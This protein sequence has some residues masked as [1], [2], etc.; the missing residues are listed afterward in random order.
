MLKLL[1]PGLAVAMAL[2]LQGCASMSPETCAASDWHQV[3]V[4][5]GEKGRTSDRIA[6]YQ[7]DCGKAGIVPDA[8]AYMAGREQGL[9]TYCTLPNG[10]QIGRRGGSYNGVCPA[11][12]QEDFL[13]GYN[14]GLSVDQAE[15]AISDVRSQISEA[16]ATLSKSETK[17]EEKSRLRNEIF[18][19]DREIIRLEAERE[20]A[21]DNA[22]QIMMARGFLN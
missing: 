18:R 12:L 7:E 5:D 9:R 19:L 16:E 21:I 11:E 20:R 2:A 8:Q 3:G 14:A 15:R 17:E 6:R 22:N 10:V 1:L 4:A 13:I